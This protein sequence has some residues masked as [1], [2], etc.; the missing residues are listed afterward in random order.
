MYAVPMT[1]DTIRDL[2]S[3]FCWAY[4]T[5]PFVPQTLGALDSQLTK[6]I[7]YGCFKHNRLL[8]TFENAE[9]NYRISTCPECDPNGE[10]EAKHA[11]CI[12]RI[13]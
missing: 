3:L 10:K 12:K 6:V 2:I 1:K 8:M 9:G 11:G 13:R 5:V 4:K 7:K